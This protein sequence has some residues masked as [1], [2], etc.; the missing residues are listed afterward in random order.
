[1]ISRFRCYNLINRSRA[2]TKLMHIIR[3][4]TVQYSITWYTTRKDIFF[5][6]ILNQ[7]RYIKIKKRTWHFDI[8]SREYFVSY[9]VSLLI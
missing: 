4:N 9:Y 2:L 5:C 1:M 6:D 7:Q 8:N 3:H